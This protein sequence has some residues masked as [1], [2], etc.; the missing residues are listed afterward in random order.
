MAAAPNGV[1]T[2]WCERAPGARW[3]PQLSP[4]A[5]ETLWMVVDCLIVSQ[6]MIFTQTV[7]GGESMPDDREG[8]TNVLVARLLLDS[9]RG[10]ASTR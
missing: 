2:V 1:S 8:E 9:D 7:S 3:W 6:T 10:R 5:T 4:L